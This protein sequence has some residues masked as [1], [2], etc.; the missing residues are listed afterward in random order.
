MCMIS[1]QG[2]PEETERFISLNSTPVKL[3]PG[4]DSMDRGTQLLMVEKKSESHPPLDKYVLVK[5]FSF[6]VDCF[7]DV[8]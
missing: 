3:D 1:E 8:V 7:N 5:H 2:S 4:M 6:V